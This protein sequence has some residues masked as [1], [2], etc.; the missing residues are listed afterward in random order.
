M[1]L[2]LVPP[3][4]RATHRIGLLLAATRPALGLNQGEAHLLAELHESGPSTVGALH[5]AFAHRKSTLTGILDRMEERGLVKRQLRAEDRRSF[6]V[7]LTPKGRQ[8]AARAH[9]RL[10]DLEGAV[11]QRVSASDLRGFQAVVEALAKEAE[12][13]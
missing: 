10:A 3:V 6:S 4:H 8:A 9:K 2:S 1:H 11:R 7:E 13:E 12:R 5:R